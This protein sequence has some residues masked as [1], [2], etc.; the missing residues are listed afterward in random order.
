MNNLRNGWIGSL[1]LLALAAA[2]NSPGQGN[3]MP[4]TPEMQATVTPTSSTA[5]KAVVERL[6]S[7][8]CD[9]EEG[10]KNVGPGAKFASRNVCMDQLRGTIGNSLNTYNCP[11]GLDIDAVDRCMAAIGGEQCSHPFDTLSRFEKCRTDLVCMR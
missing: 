8:R 7:A 9:Q 1:G 10:C 6:A 3:A 5:D 2:C 11:K 4:G